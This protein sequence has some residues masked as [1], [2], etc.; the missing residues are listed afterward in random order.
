MQ[1]LTK[2]IDTQQNKQ[3]NILTQTHIF[4]LFQIS[5]SYDSWWSEISDPEKGFYGWLCSLLH[6][7]ECAPYETVVLMTEP[8]NVKVQDCTV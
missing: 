5:L 3:T 7:E 6:V 4:F 1:I 8:L 2:H